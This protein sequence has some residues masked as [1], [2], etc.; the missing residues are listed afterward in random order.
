MALT[1]KP[2]QLEHYSKDL[3]AYYHIHAYS[4][5]PGQFATIFLDITDRVRSE[6]QLRNAKANTDLAFDIASVA[7]WERDL[8]GNDFR[9]APQWFDLVGCD[10]KDFT[11]WDQYYRSH[12]HPEDRKRTMKILQNHL[13]GLTRDYRAEFRFFNEA[14]QEY[15]WLS[16]SDA[17]WTEMKMAL[18]AHGRSRPDITLRKSRKTG[19]GART[20]LPGDFENSPAGYSM[21]P[22]RDLE[23]NPTFAIY[24]GT[25]PSGDAQRLQARKPSSIPRRKSCLP[26]KQGKRIKNTLIVKQSKGWGACHLPGQHQ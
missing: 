12:I 5:A 19:S 6:Q 7:V 20:D 1:G 22:W 13:K 26:I 3:D 8:S 21:P 23:I 15:M 24:S 11:G 9:P 25:H 14:K 10:K 17:S 18:P 16:R 4:P 2:A